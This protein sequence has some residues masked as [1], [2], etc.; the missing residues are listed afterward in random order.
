MKYKLLTIDKTQH[1][2]WINNSNNHQNVTSKLKIPKLSN[3]V[4]FTR[5]NKGFLLLLKLIMLWVSKFG[6]QTSSISN[7]WK[8]VWNSISQIPC[9][10]YWIRN[11]EGV[12]LFHLFYF[13]LED[14]CFIILYWFLSYINM[15]QS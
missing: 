11:S 8:L 6:S 7:T 14:N 4:W 15:N 13:K 12:L 3:M 2:F 1:K 9:Q 10:S 5:L